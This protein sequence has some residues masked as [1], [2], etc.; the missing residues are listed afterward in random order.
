MKNTQNITAQNTQ[1]TADGAQN[2]AQRVSKLFDRST[3]AYADIQRAV[4]VLEIETASKKKD[5][6]LEAVADIPN[7]SLYTLSLCKKHGYDFSKSRDG[8]RVYRD[9]FVAVDSWKRSNGA[10]MNTAL[11]PSELDELLESVGITPYQYNK[12][13]ERADGMTAHRLEN[14]SSS[15]KKYPSTAYIRFVDFDRFIEAVIAFLTDDDEALEAL[16]ADSD[17]A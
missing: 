13:T 6:V 1:N 3:I 10:R 14:L 8:V 4:S 9:D 2:T 11:E 15:Y 7:T 12:R 5:D 17:E 16:T